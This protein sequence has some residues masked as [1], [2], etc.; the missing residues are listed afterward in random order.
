MKYSDWLKAALEEKG[1]TPYRLQKEALAKYGD[2]AKLTQATISRLL[3]DK[4]DSPKITTLQKIAATIGIPMPIEGQVMSDD[5]DI[6]I[7]ADAYGSISIE[8]ADFAVQGILAYSA[9]FPK[10][11]ADAEWRK[12]AFKT[13]YK[14][15]FVQSLR[16]AG[17]I[18]LLKLIS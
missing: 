7:P 11:M 4:T 17:A 14:A 6:D 2:Q 8:A 18:P 1:W 3:N 16:D 5:L 9:P 15:Y 12:E 13:L 10:S